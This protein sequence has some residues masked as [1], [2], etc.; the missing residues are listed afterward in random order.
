MTNYNKGD[1]VT[2]KITRDC[3]SRITEGK[4][5]YG[6]EIVDHK[7]APK[8]ESGSFW[9]NVYKEG[10]IQNR[11][12]KTRESADKNSDI[13]RLACIEVKWTEGDGL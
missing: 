9:V 8:P 11:T 7:P 2:I 5:F 13:G 6:H 1:L 10:F 4:S 3:F 12:H